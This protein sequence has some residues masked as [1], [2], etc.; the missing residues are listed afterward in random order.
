MPHIDPA[1]PASLLERLPEEWEQLL[2]GWGQPRYRALQ[3]FHWIYQRG[4]V[5]PERMSDLPASLRERLAVAGLG[6]AMS[7]VEDQKA[8]DGTRKLLV[9]MTDG[10]RVETVLIP[11]GCVAPDDIYA[12][13]EEPGVSGAYTQCVSSQVGCA[14]GCSF[15]ASGIAG[16][17]RQMTAGEI[18]SQVLLGRACL[19]EDSRLSGVVFMGMGEPLHNYPAVARTLRI[20]NHP[21]G[22]GMSLRRVTVSTS[23]LVPEIDRLAEDFGGHVQLAVS[24][25][26][27]DEAARSEIM[28]INRKHSLASLLA[29]LSRYP[30]P[31]KRPITVEYTLIAGVND[32][33]EAAE[34]LVK[35]LR[36][37]PVKVNLIPMNEV[38]GSALTAPDATTVDAF[39]RVLASHRIPTFVRRRK[40]HDIAA[41]CGQ[42]ALRDEP[43]KIR[44]RPR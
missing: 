32:S 1:A 31:R 4:V 30:M 29:A 39:Q 40:G 2:R 18:V 24:V 12:V 38:E 9:E 5:E 7:V 8:V 37:L 35:A 16:L 11:R 36:A 23:G 10:R 3:I 22:I 27:A 13:A 20:L 34:R 33:L 28:P 14:M 26:S 44:L 43:R 15:C 17:K 25:H 42:L 41:A 6:P 21:E 19:G